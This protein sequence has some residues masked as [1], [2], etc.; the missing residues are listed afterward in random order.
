MQGNL[1]KHTLIKIVSAIVAVVLII[2][3]LLYGISL[4]TVDVEISDIEKAFANKADL[5]MTKD[6][7]ALHFTFEHGLF[8][9][10]YTLRDYMPTPY[11]IDDR[12]G[13]AWHKLS[14]GSM[15]ILAP[16]LWTYSSKRGT[17]SH[18]YCCTIRYENGTQGISIDATCNFPKLDGYEEFLDAIVA[19]I[20]SL[21]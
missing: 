20:N 17:I 18:R 15:V 13:P 6:I 12:S 2:A 1:S 5:N 3:L 9:G 21:E 10:D 14:D 4:K 19:S 8:K 11:E 7:D 16:A